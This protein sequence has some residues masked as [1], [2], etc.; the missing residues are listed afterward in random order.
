MAHIIRTFAWTSPQAGTCE[1]FLETH[2]GIGK[3]RHP[4]Y[5]NVLKLFGSG[6]RW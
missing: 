5:S 3:R 1:N 6:K 4:Q 2:C